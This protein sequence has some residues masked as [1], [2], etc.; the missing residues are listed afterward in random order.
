[1]NKQ[2]AGLKYL[3]R[4]P[5]RELRIASP[6]HHPSNGWTLVQV[7]ASLVKKNPRKLCF[8]IYQIVSQCPF[9]DYPFPNSVIKSYPYLISGLR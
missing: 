6:S 2:T 7:L 1:M 8:Y 3:A 4:P 9:V 5:N